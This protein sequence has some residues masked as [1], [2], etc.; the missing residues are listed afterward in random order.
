MV[1]SLGSLLGEAGIN[2]AQLSLGRDRTGGRA[3]AILNL[4]SPVGPDLLDR[5]RGLRGIL[6]AEQ[7]SL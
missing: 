5:I 6:W 7:V 4:D 3:I 1:G 2:I